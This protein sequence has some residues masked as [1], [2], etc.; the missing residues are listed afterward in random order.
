MAAGKHGQ[1]IQKS[2]NYLIKFGEALYAERMIEISSA[3]TM[4]KEPLELLQEMTEDIKN[5]NVQT[6][7]HPT[8]S[9]FDPDNW[10]QMGIPDGFGANEFLIFQKRKDIYKRLGILQTYTCLPMLVGN[11]PKIMIIYL[12]LGQEHNYSLTPYMELVVIVME[13][14]L[15]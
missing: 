3:H 2:I 8:M 14:L 15:I 9:A 6:T 5:I 13:R 12:G 4:P 1:G 7:L 10:K 11:I